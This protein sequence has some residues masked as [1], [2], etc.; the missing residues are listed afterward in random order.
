MKFTTE[1]VFD[2]VTKRSPLAVVERPFTVLDGNGRVGCPYVANPIHH[3]K[4]ASYVMRNVLSS[5]FLKEERFTFNLVPNN[6]DFP[7]LRGSAAGKKKGQNQ[8]VS[9]VYSRHLVVV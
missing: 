8:K 6:T 4:I 2:F 3:A 9:H 5:F 7:A 1:T